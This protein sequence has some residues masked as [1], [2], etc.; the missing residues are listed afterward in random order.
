MSQ[1]LLR[2]TGNASKV[3]GNVILVSTFDSPQLNL[4]EFAML[5]FGQEE[6][7]LQNTILEN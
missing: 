1:Q 7:T 5:Q 3:L 4:F 6:V 2:V